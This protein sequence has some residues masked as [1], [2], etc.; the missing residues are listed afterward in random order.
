MTIRMTKI[1]VGLLAFRK[2]QSRSKTEESWTIERRETEE[3][4]DKFNDI[5][6]VL[7][8]HAGN[9]MDQKGP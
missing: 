5:T 4:Q 6:D 8:R 3:Q 2:R 7:W 9:H 1:E